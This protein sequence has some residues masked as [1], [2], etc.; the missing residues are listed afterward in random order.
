MD[1]ASTIATLERLEAERKLRC[2]PAELLESTWA[3]EAQIEAVIDAILL[4]TMVGDGRAYA[5]ARHVGEWAARIAAEVPDAPSPAYIRRCGVLAAVDPAVLERVRE[6]RDYAPVVRM[7]R[8]LRMYDIDIA[9]V[10]T[11][12]LIV[13]VADEFDLLTFACDDELRY[14]PK[15]ALRIMAR[16][17][18][19][20][21]HAIVSAL[22][23]A[24]RKTSGILAAIA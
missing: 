1:Y 23:R 6:V 18:N 11:E 10:R 22:L 12:A 14:S 19:D 9:D 7:L 3:S 2:I 20:E 5:H 21:R 13:A 15:D 17:A 24:V 16:R 8:R 4:A